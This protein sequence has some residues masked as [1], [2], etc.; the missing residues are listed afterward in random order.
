M[1]IMISRRIFWWVGGSAALVVAALLA[2]MLTPRTLHVGVA[3]PKATHGWAG[4]VVYWAE[5]TKKE[6]Q[7]RYPR[8]RITLRTA[9]TAQEQI[10]Q[11]NDLYTRE[12]IDTLVILPVESVALTPPVARLK[13]S[14]LHVTVFDRGLTDPIAQ[15]A[16]VAGDNPGFG[17]L[18]GAYMIKA[19]DGRGSIVVLR[20]IPTVIDTQRFG[21][22]K[23]TIAGSQ[24]E[25]LAA[26]HADWNPV[27]AAEVMRDL[28]N[29][30]P[31]IDAVWAAD[32]DMAQAATRV[33]DSAR[34]TDIKVILGGGGAKGQIA[35]IM[36]GDRR[37]SATVTYGPSMIAKAIE[38]TVQSRLSRTAM[39]ANTIIPSVLVQ[40]DNASAYYFPE[41][42]Y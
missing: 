18:A 5:R 41:S 11:I 8:V 16:Y 29:R 20:G 10:A 30:Y 17:R 6:M 9:E 37:L 22:F 7:T 38:L 24:I 27:K 39:P 36:D 19:L 35:R 21:E 32:D 4:G 25:I 31:R 15:S 3:I 33:I 26:E 40:R 42:P 28:L 14:G 13:E 23:T 12:K 1:M 34:R 2:W